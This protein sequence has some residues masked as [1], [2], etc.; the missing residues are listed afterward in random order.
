[1]NTKFTIPRTVEAAGKQLAELDGLITARSWQRAAIVYAFVSVAD[2]K[3]K[4]PAN[5]D[6]AISPAEFAALGIAGLRSDNTVRAYRGHWQ[7]AIDQGKA[8]PVGPG[9]RVEEP[10]LPFPP[11][12]DSAAGT[13]R[14]WASRPP[15]QRAKDITE[16]LKDPEVAER[17]APSA[18]AQQ[19]VRPDV[20]RAIARNKPA[21]EAVED[22]GIEARAMERPEPW[23]LDPKAEGRKAGNAMARQL[24][25]DLATGALRNAA[26]HLAEAI[27]TREEFGIEHPDQEAEAL[28][29]V[30]RYLA[31]YKGE[32]EV[33]DEDRQWLDAMGVT[34]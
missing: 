15:E 7:Y 27:V 3:G 32:A 29:K 25:T 31:A 19:A 34:A 26:G 8:K 10:D 2:G 24:K 16:A 5:R 9:S 18:I 17:V 12:P 11:N 4:A 1:M 28:A 6:S 13:S 20:A 14:S 22:E 30:E 21:R 23:G 33:T